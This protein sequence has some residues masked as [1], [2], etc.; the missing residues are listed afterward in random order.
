MKSESLSFPF[1]M[2]GME[3]L[4][5]MANLPVEQQVKFRL[6]TGKDVPTVYVC[7]LINKK[8][9]GTSICFHF[10][11]TGS[12]LAD[13]VLRDFFD[14]VGK[15]IKGKLGM[16]SSRD[17]WSDH[18]NSLDFDLPHTDDEQDTAD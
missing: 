16:T 9:P 6:G 18:I 2:E 1:E 7:V 4:L 13:Q 11:S 12:D 14:G 8:Q 10:A 17:V 5:F 15:D 3:V